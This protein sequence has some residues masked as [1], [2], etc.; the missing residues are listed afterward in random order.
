VSHAALGVTAIVAVRN[1]YPTI[2]ACLDGERLPWTPSNQGAHGRR[3]SNGES[4][5]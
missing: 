4:L 5:E 1:G 2:G 3:G